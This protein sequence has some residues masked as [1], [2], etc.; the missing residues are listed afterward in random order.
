MSRDSES[1]CIPSQ[2]KNNKESA[3]LNDAI[4]HMLT[5]IGIAYMSYLKL[6]VIS[7]KVN[8]SLKANRNLKLKLF[9]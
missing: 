6:H 7:C 4:G 5:I 2:V 8:A 1:G 3:N 9:P